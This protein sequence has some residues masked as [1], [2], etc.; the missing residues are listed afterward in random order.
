MPTRNNIPKGKAFGYIQGQYS[1]PSMG[2]AEKHAKIR[3]GQRANLVKLGI[4]PKLVKK[5][6]SGQTDSA[7]KKKGKNGR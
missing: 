7:P 3:S 2:L 1:V 5:I 4:D 6:I